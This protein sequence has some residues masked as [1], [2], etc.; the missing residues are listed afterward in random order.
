MRI[1]KIFLL[2]SL[3]AVGYIS[4]EELLPTTDQT[5]AGLK[6][7]LNLGIKNAVVEVSKP[8]GY[9]NDVIKINL[10][11]GA[12]STFAVINALRSKNNLIIDMALDQ[13][14][15]DVDLENTL[16]ILINSAAEDAAPKSVNVF[17][18]AIT[19]MTI[20]DGKSILFGEND[21]ATQY[22]KTNTYTQLQTAFN[23]TITKSLETISIAGVTPVEAWDKVATLNNKLF[24]LINT[25]SVASSALNSLG[26]SLKPMETN[27]SDYVTGKALDGL[28]VKVAGEESK[29]RTDVNARTS[30]LLRKVFGQ[31]D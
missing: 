8:G 10:P 26:I 2:I 4:C 16:T 28:F 9:L 7:A 5:V 17:V 18:S 3:L 19:G 23:P 1:K 25:V 12:Q 6:E 29:I 20:S 30:D 27:L 11:E 21:A 15:I 22:L 31:L 24:N 14:N 13:L